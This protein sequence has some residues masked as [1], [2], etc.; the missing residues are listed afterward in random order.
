[1]FDIATRFAPAL[2]NPGAQPLRLDWCLL[3][4]E[5]SGDGGGGG[6]GIAWDFQMSRGE[7]GGWYDA[8][9]YQSWGPER[10]PYNFV[11]TDGD[12]IQLYTVAQMPSEYGSPARLF[13]D[14]EMGYV[15]RFSPEFFPGHDVIIVSCL[16]P[17]EGAP[18]VEVITQG[19]ALALEDTLQTAIVISL[20]TD[21]RAGQDDH[22]PR[23]QTDKRG[24]CG[25]EF[26]APDAAPWGS[27]LWLLPAKA[28]PDVLERARFA[29][30]EALAWLVP[31][32]LAQRVSVDAQWHGSSAANQRLALRIAIYRGGQ[33][34]PVYDVLWGTSIARGQTQLQTSL[35]AGDAPR[36]AG[37]LP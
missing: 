33:I 12:G 7:W 20:F 29:A 32:G 25:E 1:M 8:P 19:V 36:L 30:Q 10:R 18:P 13:W 5:E 28:M 2:P 31:A 23:G 34:K 16:V 24:W 11:I 22:L 35:Y 6:S 9:W 27:K 26:V 21:A 3:S 14:E 17:D 4:F 37:N 15:I